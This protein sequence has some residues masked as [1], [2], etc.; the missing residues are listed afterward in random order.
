MDGKKASP[1]QPGEFSNDQFERSMAE[2][3]EAIRI[4][5]ESLAPLQKNTEE[6]NSSKQNIS[7]DQPARRPASSAPQPLKPVGAG[8]TPTPSKP[9]QMPVDLPPYYP[10]GLTVRTWDAIEGSI[11]AFSNQDQVLEWCKKVMSELTPAFAAEVKA[12]RLRAD[13]APSTMSEL[14]HSLL[15]VNCKE[16]S[17]SWRELKMSKERRS[18][19]RVLKK[20]ECSDS[21]PSAPKPRAFTHSSDYRSVTVRG[22]NFTLT[23][24]QAQTIQILDESRQSGTP[25]VGKDYLLEQLG[26][27]SSRLRDS[28]KTSLAAWKALVKIGLKKGT[29]RL[30]V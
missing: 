8:W 9:T 20:L 6:Q 22:E 17:E 25:D 26:T 5:E 23:S 15:V 3:R 16:S 28:F 10:N 27:P 18:F 11:K 2:A 21:Q 30:S 12:G 14:L 7:E 24:R 13:L 1:Q 4:G 29:Y 19:I